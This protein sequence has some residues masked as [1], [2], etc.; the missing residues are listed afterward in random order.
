MGGVTRFRRTGLQVTPFVVAV[1]RL[2]EMPGPVGLGNMVEFADG[3]HHPD[4]PGPTEGRN[5][6][7]GNA[8]S[9]QPGCTQFRLVGMCGC[10]ELCGLQQRPW[11]G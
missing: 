7:T 11:G 1:R 6:A 2:T 8:V 9:H 3:L 10:R 5:G 4:T